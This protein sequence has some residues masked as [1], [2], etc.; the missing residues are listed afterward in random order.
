MRLDKKVPWYSMIAIVS[1]L[2]LPGMGQAEIYFGAMGG[3]SIPNDFSDVTSTG[4]FPDIPLPDANLGTSAMAGGKA[5]MY[6]PDISWLGFETEGYWTAPEF[7]PFV[8]QGVDANL[9]V[10]TWGFN[11]LLRYPGERFQPYVGAGVGVF[12]AEIDT[13]LAGPD[14][15][16][17][18]VPGFTL[19]GGFRGFVTESLALFIEYKY[20][21]A[22]F[23]LRTTIFEIPFGFEG[24]YS[25]NIVGAGISYHF[26]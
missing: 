15:S 25:T 21:Q 6:L 17:S 11:A 2:L 18:W 14:L 12:F 24:T 4:R 7:S 22:T 23:D 8:A 10:I 5:G 1:A 3:M 13:N 26:R 9:R 16:Q 19:L 20:N